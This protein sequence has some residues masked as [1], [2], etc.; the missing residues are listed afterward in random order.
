MAK[1]S[2]HRTPIWVKTQDR[3]R[4][5]HRTWAYENRSDLSGRRDAV[6]NRAQSLRNRY[7]N[8]PRITRAAR[9][10]GHPLANASH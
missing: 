5:S 2:I 7:G 8:D 1:E 3:V 10:M 4:I 6:A 9:N